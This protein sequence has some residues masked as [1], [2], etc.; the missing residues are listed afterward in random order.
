MHMSSTSD[1][2]STKGEKDT[3][4]TSKQSSLEPKV[5]AKAKVAPKKKAAIKVAP[6]FASK[7]PK[8]GKAK[9]DDQEFEAD[10]DDEEDDD[11]QAVKTEVE[12][13]EDD[14]EEEDDEEDIAVNA[15][16]TISL[17]RRREDASS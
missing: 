17:L 1:A 16:R 3:V 7:A 11:D 15:V 5:K 2:S 8:K 14:D 12:E 6:I 13:E 9:K 10:E 4:A